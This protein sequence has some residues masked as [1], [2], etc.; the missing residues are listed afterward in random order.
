M[1]F[2]QD[3]R[4][5]QKLNFSLGSKRVSGSFLEMSIETPQ[6]FWEDVVFLLSDLRDLV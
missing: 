6:D 2:A 1:S 5:L 4:P 3:I